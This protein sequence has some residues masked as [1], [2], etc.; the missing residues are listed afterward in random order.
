MLLAWG[1]VCD[2]SSRSVVGGVLPCSAIPQ[3]LL[4]LVVPKGCA[5]TAMLSGQPPRP[6]AIQFSGTRVYAPALHLS[7]KSEGA[8]GGTTILLV[9]RWQR[10]VKP[11]QCSHRII[12]G[13]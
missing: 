3:S 8:A 13:I 7:G 5:I 4:A 6:H 1:K 9:A 11:K 10:A 2:R 12:P